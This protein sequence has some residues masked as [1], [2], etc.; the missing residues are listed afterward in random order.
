MQFYGISQE[1]KTSELLKFIGVIIIGLAW[2]LGFNPTL[3][4]LL[5]LGGIELFFLSL[6]N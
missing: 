2:V 3:G 4:V 5:F 6:F 1:N